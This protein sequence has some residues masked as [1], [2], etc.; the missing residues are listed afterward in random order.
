ME[1]VVKL[2]LNK[3]KNNVFEYSNILLKTLVKEDTKYDKSL[4]DIIE[5]YMKV[6]YLEHFALIDNNEKTIEK[7]KIFN[8]ITKIA[9]AYFKKTK[10][11]EV[12]KDTFFVSILIFI[13][14]QI[15]DRTSVLLNTSTSPIEDIINNYEDLTEP[16]K[17]L[18]ITCK[19]QLK[20]LIKINTSIE[21]KF[22]LNI[23]SKDFKLFYRKLATLKNKCKIFEVF[24]KRTIKP[25]EKYSQEEVDMLIEDNNLKDKINLILFQLILLTELKTI[26]LNKTNYFVIDLNGLITKKKNYNLFENLLNDELKRHLIFKINFEELNERTDY[27]KELKEQGYK[28]LISDLDHDKIKNKDI[29]KNVNYILE[30]KSFYESNKKFVIY[31]EDYKII[32]INK[33]EYEEIDEKQLLE[34]M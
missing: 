5:L 9:S 10:L 12:K 21:K 29:Y 25:L 3:K 28:F 13:S 16:T 11:E 19:K 23:N 32:L 34:M 2:Y 27:V 7:S 6:N 22:L 30:T 31:C 18:I 1:N 33:K 20:N 15:E 14:L 8:Q 17:K 4:K 26:I 24:L